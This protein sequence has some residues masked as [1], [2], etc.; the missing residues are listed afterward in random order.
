MDRVANIYGQRRE[1]A[2]TIPKDKD[3]RGRLLLEMLAGSY[4]KFL[5]HLC[6]QNNSQEEARNA[7]EIEGISSS[8]QLV[9]EIRIHQQLSHE[10]V[11]HLDHWFED[12]GYQY[13]FM[14]YCSQGVHVSRGRIWRKSC[15]ARR[16]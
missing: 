12:D 1:D 3:S 7:C 11:V 13:I 2:E 5:E 14:E 16:K 6:R 8:P 4:I 9:Y 10:N 15:R